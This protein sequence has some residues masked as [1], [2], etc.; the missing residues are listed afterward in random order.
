VR[1][2]GRL[3][4]LKVGATFAH[5]RVLAIVD[6]LEVTVVALDTGEV[7][8]SHL[9]ESATTCTSSSPRSAPT[10]KPA[11]LAWLERHPRM[12][13]HFTPTSASWLNQIET[14]FGILTRQAIHRGS[15][16][17]VSALISAIDRFT[18]TWNEGHTPFTWVRTADEILA[19]AVRKRPATS[20]SRH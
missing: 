3:H 14:W 1:R 2:A 17:D 5:R 6:E 8:S 4:H 12:T 15:F 13:F 11:V 19:K 9:I 7:L 18:A 10:T 16:E 20:E